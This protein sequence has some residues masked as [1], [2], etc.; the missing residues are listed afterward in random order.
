M[1]FTDVLD[2]FKDSER[3]KGVSWV[4]KLASE[5]FQMFHGVSGRFRAY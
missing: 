3:F 4:I 2:R 5:G 1:T